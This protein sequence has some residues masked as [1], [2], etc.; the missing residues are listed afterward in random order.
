[1][2]D[3]E[4]DEF[5]CHL[6]C[7]KKTWSI[8][9]AIYELINALF[10]VR[11]MIWILYICIIFL[12]YIIQYILP[13][14]YHPRYLCIDCARLC[15]GFIFHIYIQ[16]QWYISCIDQYRCWKTL[17]KISCSQS[18][19]YGQHIHDIIAIKYLYFDVLGSQW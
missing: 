16:R 15:N 12:S 4:A 1:M 18:H 2:H 10:F 13:H 3:N 9:I 8:F 14:R 17:G 19:I 5:C 11:A 6:W 7:R